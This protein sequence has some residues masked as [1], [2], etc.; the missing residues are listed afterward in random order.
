M[1]SAGVLYRHSSSRTC[2]NAAGGPQWDPPR[3]CARPCPRSPQRSLGSDL[4]I[5]PCPVLLP[6]V[7][8]VLGRLLGPTVR[9]RRMGE[10]GNNQHGSGA[11]VD[12]TVRCRGAK[13][14]DRCVDEGV[15]Q[16]LDHEAADLTYVVCAPHRRFPRFL[17]ALCRQCSTG[18]RTA[19]VPESLYLS[20]LFGWVLI[21]FLYSSFERFCLRGSVAAARSTSGWF[22]FAVFGSGAGRGLIFLG[23]FS[24]WAFGPCLWGRFRRVVPGGCSLGLGSGLRAFVFSGWALC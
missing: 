13:G 8:A 19:G 22:L 18:C 5:D 11:A 23:D 6:G 3:A 10:E 17:A 12:A 24:G 14:V 16:P 7:M 15:D 2:G 9:S 20:C 21:G 4:S 1:G